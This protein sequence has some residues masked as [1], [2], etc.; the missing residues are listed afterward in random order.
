MA[1]TAALVPVFF[2]LHVNLATP[3]SPAIQ[4]I[5]SFSTA[6]LILLHA[7]F[8]MYWKRVY[9]DPLTEI[10]NRQS[11]DERLHTLTGDYALAMV[12]VDHFKQFNDTYGHS[13]GDNVLRMVAK[14]L[15]DYFGNNAYRYGGEEFCL[16]FEGVATKEAERLSNEARKELEKTEFVL[17]SHV[18]RKTEDGKKNRGSTSS[19]KKVGVTVSI[20]IAAKNGRL[21]TYEQVLKQADKALYQAKDSGRNR[22]V[23]Q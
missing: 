7:I 3:A 4:T 5:I 10:P 23:V 12:D 8:Y 15:Q 6:T 14:H 17:R 11:L 21:Q 19:G 2:A 20:G 9:R 13:E 18:R 16:V 1:L 22:V